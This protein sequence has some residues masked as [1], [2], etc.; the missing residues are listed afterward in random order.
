MEVR[1]D[2]TYNRWPQLQNFAHIYDL[3]IFPQST[4][5]YSLCQIVYY[6]AVHF[7][8]QGELNW[9]LGSVLLHAESDIKIKLASEKAWET[10]GDYSWAMWDLSSRTV[11]IGS[12]AWNI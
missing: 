12:Y 3:Q 7:Y 1:I 5:G 4:W 6:V 2:L 10:T 11:A 8:S 9:W